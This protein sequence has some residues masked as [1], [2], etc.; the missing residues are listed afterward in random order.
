MRRMGIRRCRDGSSRVGSARLSGNKEVSTHSQEFSGCRVC[1]RSTHLPTYPC[2]TPRILLVHGGR[3]RTSAA[4]WCMF[5][6]V[7][8]SGVSGAP[9]ATP[10]RASNPLLRSAPLL[11]MHDCADAAG[12]LITYDD[13]ARILGLSGHR[14]KALREECDIIAHA[15]VGTSCI[16]ELVMDGCRFRS[17]LCMALNDIIESAMLCEVCDMQLSSWVTRF[18]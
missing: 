16:V 9:P 15:A 8:A 13:C 5:G 17:Y 2:P 12:D 18:R 4:H 7:A 14:L 11:C 10:A 3:R 1:G 6:I